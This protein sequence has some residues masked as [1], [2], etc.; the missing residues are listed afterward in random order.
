M[1]LDIFSKEAQQ[2]AI[3]GVPGHVG[4]NLSSNRLTEQ[5]EV[6]HKV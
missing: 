3:L 6:S 2:R 5:V 4:S 1:Q